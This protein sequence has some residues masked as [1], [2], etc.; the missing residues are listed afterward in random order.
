MMFCLL[1]YLHTDIL[2]P[3]INLYPR[4]SDSRIGLLIFI[5]HLGFYTS[6]LNLMV[7]PIL[8]CVTITKSEQHCWLKNHKIAYMLTLI[9]FAISYLTCFLS[10]QYTIYLKPSIPMYLIFTI[11]CSNFGRILN[12]EQ[13]VQKK[14]FL[15][16][17]LWSMIVLLWYHVVNFP[18]LFTVQ[19]TRSS[20]M[21][22]SVFFISFRLLGFSYLLIKIYRYFR[23]HDFSYLLESSLRKLDVAFLWYVIWCMASLCEWLLIYSVFYLIII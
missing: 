11:Y 1:T 10:I 23:P 21:D 18:F 9:L 8:E 4:I 22:L 6:V 2:F 14:D 5:K 12:V 3:F 15:Y 19:Q 13:H 20:F 7:I 17:F 16:C